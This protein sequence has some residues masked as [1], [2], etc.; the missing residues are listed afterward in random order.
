MKKIITKKFLIREYDK[1]KKSQTQTVKTMDCSQMTVGNYLRKFKLKIRPNSNSGK[2][3]GRYIDGRYSEQY[4]CKDC[5]KEISVFSGVYGG[6]RC[7]SCARKYDIIT[8]PEKS[9]GKNNGMYGKKFSKK[10]K[11]KFSEISKRKW[12]DLKFREKTIKATW[13][14]L[15]LTPNKK[16][17]KLIELLNKIFSNTYKF[18][19]DGK[20]IIGGFCP[21]FIHK[22]KKKIIELYGDYWHNRKDVKERD[23]RR[24]KTYKKCGYRTLI[25]WEKELGNLEKLE[26]KILVFNYE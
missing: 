8:N 12:K 2:N 1:N 6:G 11:K 3:N 23:K 22:N 18:V 16:E 10:Q 9:K 13:K 21:D 5:G 20:L 14:A 19:G 26:S 25:V 17:L 7:R 4:F 24:I 15:K